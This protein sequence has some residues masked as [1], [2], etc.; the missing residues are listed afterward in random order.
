MIKSSI[1]KAKIRRS[2]VSFVDTFFDI[3]DIQKHNIDN[4]ILSENEEIIVLYK[5]DNNYNWVLT[6]INFYIPTNEIIIKLS[7]LV[8][9]DFEELKKNPEQKRVNKELTLFTKNEKYRVLFEEGTWHVFYNLFLFI[10]GKN[11][12]SNR[13]DN[14]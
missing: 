10:I 14:K 3:E 4:L 5:K 12:R 1:I 2:K 11:K 13:V 6:N 7:D 8:K 9:V